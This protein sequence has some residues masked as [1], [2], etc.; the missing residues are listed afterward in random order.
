MEDKAD[1]KWTLKREFTYGQLVTVLGLS[2][3]ALVFTVRLEG[4]D[5]VN[6][7]ATENNTIAIVAVNGRMTTQY[8]EIIR[9]LERIADKVDDK[10][11]K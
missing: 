1:Q 4:A 3:A 6:S 10:V 5:A 2:V 11:D 7:E 8:Q 9:R